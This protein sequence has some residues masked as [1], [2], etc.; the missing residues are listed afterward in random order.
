MLIGHRNIFKSIK[1]S[2]LT[3]LFPVV[4]TYTDFSSTEKKLLAQKYP[5][6]VI[7]GSVL[8]HIFTAQST[9]FYYI[10]F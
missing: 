2:W 8:Y 5:C 9:K 10:S 7:I 3:L 1:Y 6:M 4:P